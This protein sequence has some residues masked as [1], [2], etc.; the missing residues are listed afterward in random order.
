MQIEKSQTKVVSLRAIYDKLE[1]F[2][3]LEVEVDKK[4]A[5]MVETSDILFYEVDMLIETGRVLA[6]VMTGQP[7][8][9]K[10]AVLESFTLHT[11][12]LLDFLYL[13][14]PK[15]P[16]DVMALHFL[17]EPN[18]WKTNRPEKSQILESVHARVGTEV[19]H[20][21]Y[22]RLE[23]SSEQRQWHFVA[24]AEEV[25]TILNKLLKLVQRER[26]SETIIERLYIEDK[27]DEEITQ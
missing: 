12:V 3:L 16:D 24:I 8:V 17:D 26:L 4:N 11:R 22:K 23:I 19:A 27:P 14:K 1:M 6:S 5:R 9:I 7:R 15:W 25:A 10:N 20:L 21:T 2:E 18:K 13:D